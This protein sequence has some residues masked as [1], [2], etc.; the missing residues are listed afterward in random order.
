M[1]LMDAIILQI[2]PLLAQ[3]DVPQVGPPSRV[4]HA[5]RRFPFFVVEGPRG[6]ILRGEFMG[7]DSAL[8]MFTEPLRDEE[9]RSF[10]IPPDLRWPHHE[11]QAGMH[12]AHQISVEDELVVALGKNAWGCCAA[13]AA[14][15]ANVVNGNIPEPP[16]QSQFLLDDHIPNCFLEHVGKGFR[17]CH[18]G[19]RP[20]EHADRKCGRAP[21]VIG[22]E[23][24]DLQG[25]EEVPV[26]ARNRAEAHGAHDVPS[27]DQGA[28]TVSAR[29]PIEVRRLA[30]NV[31]HKCRPSLLGDV[32]V[33]GADGFCCERVEVEYDHASAAFFQQCCYVLCGYLARHDQL[34]KVD[35][36]AHLFWVPTATAVVELPALCLEALLV[37]LCDPAEPFLGLSAGS[38]KALTSWKSQSGAARPVIEYG[39]VV[40]RFSATSVRGA[41]LAFFCGIFA[42]ATAAAALL[43]SGCRVLESPVLEA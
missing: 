16:H 42:A 27:P 38:G 13:T 20:P 15:L 14:Q 34:D 5:A 2:V 28:E 33:S 7:A 40:T 35:C 22:R 30:D 43:C 21:V 3:L 19:V 26:V 8:A 4:V 11:A 18:R 41:S 12:H 9:S 29:A 17:P 24:V 23:H 31:S 6:Q 37:L 32:G 39:A 25:L 1:Q 36:R 10:V